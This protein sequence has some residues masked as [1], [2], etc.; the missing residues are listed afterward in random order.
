MVKQLKD[1]YLV[2]LMLQAREGLTTEFWYEENKG[3]KFENRLCVPKGA[4]L[5][6]KILCEAHAGAYSVHLG[7]DK[8]VD[9]NKK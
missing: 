3:L 4:E 1:P 5:R 7:R 8:M 2:Q 9:K 6:N